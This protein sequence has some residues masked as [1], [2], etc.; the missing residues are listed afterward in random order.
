MVCVPSSLSCNVLRTSAPE[1]GNPP[2]L[3]GVLLV[4][5][6]GRLRRTL[7]GARGL[8]RGR[9][10]HTSRCGLPQEL[11][12]SS[13][14]SHLRGA[15]PPLRPPQLPA[16][17]AGLASHFHSSGLAAWWITGDLPPAVAILIGY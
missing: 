8:C 16:L 3:R 12:R 7:R 15:Q 6:F 17:L 11:A 14:W 4:R 2:Q 9:G 13:A 5:Y 10:L 1:G